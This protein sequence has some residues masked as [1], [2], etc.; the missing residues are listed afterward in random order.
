V[1]IEDKTYGDPTGEGD[2]YTEEGA[3]VDVSGSAQTERGNMANGERRLG[4]QVD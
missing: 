4:K 3:R 1:V 2:P